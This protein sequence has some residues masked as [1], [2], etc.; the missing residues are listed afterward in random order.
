[1]QTNMAKSQQ[2]LQWYVVDA[3]DK[4]L[5]RLA[6]KLA[7]RLRGKHLCDFTPHVNHGDHIIVINARQIVVTG[8]KFTDKVYRHYT[9]YPGGQKS[10]SFK[11]LQEK[12]PERILEKAIRGMLPKTTLGRAMFRKLKV[13]ADSQHPHTAQNPILLEI[14]ES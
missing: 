12:F 7:A 4:V 8:K 14:L 5:G 6:S 13:Y 1:M 11:A 9:G 3:K 2:T 10:I